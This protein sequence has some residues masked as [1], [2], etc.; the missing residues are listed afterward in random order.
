MIFVVD[1]TDR[2][3]DSITKMELFNLFINEE[4]K[5]ATFLIFG[6]KQD[7]EGAM[8]PAEIIEKFNLNEIKNNTWHIQ[9]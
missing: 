1:S 8:N 4:L 5:N 9:V 2:K 3:N 7:L 6:N